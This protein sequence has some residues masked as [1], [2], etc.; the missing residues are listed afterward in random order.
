VLISL[1]R[2]NN[3]QKVL[4]AFDSTK[5][6]FRHQIYPEYKIH[7]LATP[8]KLLQQINILKSLLVKSGVPVVELI[9][10][11]ADDLIASFFDQNKK[12]HLD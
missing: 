1:L 9:N 6:N 4:V 5:I 11:E 10:F 12:L 8:P 7:R 2:G 3:Y